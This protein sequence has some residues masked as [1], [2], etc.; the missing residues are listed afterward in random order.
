MLELVL[1]TLRQGYAAGISG[2][3]VGVDTSAKA[4]CGVATGSGALSAGATPQ[5]SPECRGEHLKASSRGTEPQ[6]W[7]FTLSLGSGTLYAEIRVNFSFWVA[8]RNGETGFCGGLCGVP[9]LVAEP[10]ARDR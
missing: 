2:G 4:I 7:P 8:W 9:R 5:K 3:G 10:C 6:R 1:V